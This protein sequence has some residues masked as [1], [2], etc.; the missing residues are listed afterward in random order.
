MES[1]LRSRLAT[2]S[3]VY[4]LVG[5]VTTPR[6]FP[7]TRTQDSILP[8]IIF[9]INSEES[10]QAF[11]GEKARKADFEVVAVATTKLAAIAIADAVIL[12]LDG[13]VDS[14]TGTKIMHCLHSRSV[15][16]YQQ[17]EAGETTGAFLHTTVFS[18]MYS[19]S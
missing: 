3:G 19:Q 16:S 6:V 15:S 5:G 12:C 7:E 13:F 8:A 4:N 2:T 14:A 1:V 9:G 10:I 18:V 11:S 17:P